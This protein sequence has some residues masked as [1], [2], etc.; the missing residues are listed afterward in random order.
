LTHSIKQKYNFL[1]KKMSRYTDKTL[2]SVF[3][4]TRQIEGGEVVIGQTETVSFLVLPYDAIEILDYL[5]LGKTVGETRLIYQEKYG[6]VPDIEDLL[7][8]LEQ[9]G[10]VK[11]LCQNNEHHSYLVGKSQFIL[12]SA[13]YRPVRYHFSNFPQ[14]LAQRLLSY[15]V[16]MGCGALVGLSLAAIAFDL[17][18]IPGWQVYF[19][20]ENSTLMILTLVV[21]D[22]ITL[23]FHEMA[24]LIAARA[25]GVSCRMGISNRMWMLVAETD[26][27][28]IWSIPR[29]QRYLP[30]LAGSLLDVVCAAVLVLIFFA[31]RQGWFVIPGVINQLGQALLLNYLLGLLWQCYF[32]MRTDFYYV[33]ANFFKCKSLMKDT[34]DFVRNKIA[35]IYRRVRKVDQSHIPKRERRIIG[36]YALLLLLAF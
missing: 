4:F 21:L 24:H 31:E 8:A 36:L 11:P 35:K 10:F 30:F 3:P 2:V 23:F 7:N 15:P 19:F 27:T 29:Q 14:V 25:L 9:K 1:F 22:C 32:F 28:G 18:L 34:E 12:P 5:A 17:S 26:M 20:Q 16:L 13:T 33:I 6:E